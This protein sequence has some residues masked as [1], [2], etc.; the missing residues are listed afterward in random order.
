M[1]FLKIQKLCAKGKNKERF[2]SFR[3]NRRQECV[4]SLLMES[5]FIGTRKI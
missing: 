2:E 1:I 5:L 4:V 3:Y